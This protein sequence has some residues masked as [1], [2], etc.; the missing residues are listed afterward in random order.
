M[1]IFYDKSNYFA[2]LCTLQRVHP[3]KPSNYLKR[4]WKKSAPGKIK[5]YNIHF[6]YKTHNTAERRAPF[7][8][9]HNETARI[10]AEKYAKFLIFRSLSSSTCLKKNAETEHD[11]NYGKI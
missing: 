2:Q 9:Y 11:Q 1:N 5:I 6:N 3:R 7:M 8:I 10:A 4:Y